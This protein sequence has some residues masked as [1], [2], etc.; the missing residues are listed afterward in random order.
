MPRL[1]IRDFSGG[2][3]TNQSEFDISEN[4]YTAFENVM[5]KM[6]GRLEKFLNDSDASGGIT[7]LND[8]QTELVLYRTEKDLMSNSNTAVWWVVG[9]GTVLRRQSA[10]AGTGGTFTTITT[11]WG[12]YPLY[13][14]LV[15]NQILRI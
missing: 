10:S 7:S 2:L 14:F 9:N 15:H 11:G 6:P 8:M 12:S 1:R 4:Q 13:D 5:N 3:V